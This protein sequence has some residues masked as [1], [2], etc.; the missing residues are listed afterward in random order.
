MKKPKLK[1]CPCCGGKPSFILGF[2]RF[3]EEHHT[4][5]ISCSCGIGTRTTIYEDDEDLQEL[6][7]IWNRRA[8]NDT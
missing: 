7:D 1:R 5:T 2:V 8:E 4:V 3:K 6:A